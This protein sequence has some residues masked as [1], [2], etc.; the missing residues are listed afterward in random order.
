MFIYTKNEEP[1][2]V[3]RKIINLSQFGQVAMIAFGPRFVVRAG[4]IDIA[5]KWTKEEAQSVI[6]RIFKAIVEGKT[7]L[8]LNDEE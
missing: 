3:G 8:D 7:Y 1:G 6:D 4:G 5:D 2:H